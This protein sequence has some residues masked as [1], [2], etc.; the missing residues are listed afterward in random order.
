MIHYLENKVEVVDFAKGQ[1]PEG[2]AGFE[3]LPIRWFLWNLLLPLYFW[4]NNIP[5]KKI[6][7]TFKICQIMAVFQKFEGKTTTLK[8]WIQK[9]KGKTTTL[10][11]LNQKYE[12][13]TTKGG[14]FS[15]S[16]KSPNLQKKIFQK[17]IVDLKFFPDLLKRE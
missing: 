8:N 12:E 1:G 13:K 16:A 14:F 2:P 3:I 15:E 9:F 17:T 6:K 5:E 11:F 7:I 10:N 4:G